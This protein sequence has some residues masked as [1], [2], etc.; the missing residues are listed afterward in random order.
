MCPL[1]PTECVVYTIS[2]WMLPY[3][4][5]MHSNWL[6]AH[7]YVNG[8][9]ACVLHCT[10]RN[11][12][13]MNTIFALR[14]YQVEG[15]KTIWLKLHLH[16]PEYFSLYENLHFF[17]PS[18]SEPSPP[19]AFRYTRKIFT[20]K[21]WN[22][23]NVTSFW[24]HFFNILHCCCQCASAISKRYDYLGNQSVEQSHDCPVGS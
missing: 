2:L 7:K 4:A 24:F 13:Y 1:E 14:K 10:T 12:Y 16:G 15:Y 17:S 21:I 8:D 6:Y 11:E 20:I 9:L 19:E 3:H 5:Y 18:D 22:K 23:F